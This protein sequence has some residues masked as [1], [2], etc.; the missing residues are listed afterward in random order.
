MDQDLT[1]SGSKFK[2]APR[3]VT[4][5]E[6]FCFREKYN[7]IRKEIMDQNEIKY[8]DAISEIDE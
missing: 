8:V 6:F 5:N 7:P 4:C 3:R 2:K 1:V